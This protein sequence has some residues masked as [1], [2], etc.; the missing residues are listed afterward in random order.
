MSIWSDKKKLGKFD[1]MYNNPAK[2]RL[3]RKPREWPWS[4]WRFYYSNGASVIA[5]HRVP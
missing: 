3:V 2:R 1:Y 5:M 4:T